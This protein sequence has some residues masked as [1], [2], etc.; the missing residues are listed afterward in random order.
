MAG[1][2]KN[3]C[4]LLAKVGEHLGVMIQLLDDLDGV[5]APDGQGDLA[6]QKY[7]NAVIVH[8]LHGHHSKEVRDLLMHKQAEA[9]S[10]LLLES[11]SASAVL[12][13]AIQ[14]RTLALQTLE[15]IPPKS[16]EMAALGS[17]RLA[18]FAYGVFSQLP[19]PII[20]WIEVSQC[21]IHVQGKG[22]RKKLKGA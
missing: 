7:C 14:E 6:T 21:A 9:L 15:A 5:F 17:K 22:K 4:S 13:A 10:R 11:G 20:Q 16:G 19:A 1:A 3:E 18:N 8:G 2:T 12:A